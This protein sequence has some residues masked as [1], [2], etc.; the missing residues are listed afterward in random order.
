MEHTPDLLSQ[1]PDIQKLDIV[2]EK[3]QS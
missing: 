1:T 2:A 3:L